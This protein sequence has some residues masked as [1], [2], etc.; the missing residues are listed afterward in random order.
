M[1]LDYHYEDYIRTGSHVQSSSGAGFYNGMIE[2]FRWKTRSATN[3][4]N[5]GADH[6]AWSTTNEATLINGTSEELMYKY[7][8][9]EQY[10]LNIATFGV[11]NNTT[12]PGPATLTMNFQ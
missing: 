6:A 7:T 9:N 10:R 4:V 12:T 2:A 1:A 5:N 3:G 8:Y 11:F